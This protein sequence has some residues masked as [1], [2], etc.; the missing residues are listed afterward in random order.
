MASRGRTA[1]TDNDGGRSYDSSPDPLAMSM[2]ENTTQAIRHKAAG[3][4]PLMTNS[5]SKQNRTLEISGMDLDSPAKSMVLNTPRAGGASPWRIKVTVQAEPGSDEENTMSPS[6]KRVTRTKTTTVPLKDPDAQSPVK[7][8]RGRPRKSDTGIAAKPRRNGTPVK[9]T[10]RSKSRDASVGAA[11]SSA[12][13]VDTD[14]PPKKRRGRPRKSIQPPTEDEET[15]NIQDLVSDDE[16]FANLTPVPPANSKATGSKKTTRFATPKVASSEE[17]ADITQHAE[18]PSD[19]TPEINLGERLHGRKGTPH[20]KKTSLLSETA[21]DGSDEGSEMLTPS[22][23]EDEPELQVYDPDKQAADEQANPTPRQIFEEEEETHNIDNYAFDEG[24]TRMPDD[25]TVLDSENF[26]MISVDSL[27]SNG[28]FSSPPKPEDS[29]GPTNRSIGT[30]LDTISGLSSVVPPRTVVQL[31]SSHSSVTSNPTERLRSTASPRYSTPVVE[32]IEQPSEPPAIQVAPPAIPKAVTP[33]I[34]RVV[35][36]GVALQGLVDTNRTTP[37]PLQKTHDEKRDQLDDLF[38]GFSEGTRKELHAGLRLGEQLADGQI[39]LPSPEP[40]S[41][42]KPTRSV[43][44]REGVFRTQRKS[45]SRLL[46]PEEQEDHV[47]VTE[48]RPVLQDDVQYPLLDTEEAANSLISPASSEDGMNSRGNTPPASTTSAA[49]NSNRK[50]EAEGMNP[51]LVASQT[52]QDDYADI[53]Q[54]EASRSSNSLED[55][56]QPSQGPSPGTDLFTDIATTVPARGK[57]IRTRRHRAAAAPQQSVDAKSTQQLTPPSAESGNDEAGFASARGSNQALEDKDTSDTNED[58]DDTGMFFQSNM[59]TVF[60]T[61]TNQRRQRTSEKASLS[62]LLDQGE[63]LLPESSPPAQAKEASPTTTKANPFLGTPPRFP[64]FPCSPSKSSPLRREIRGSDIS[65][66][67]IQ[68]YQDESSLPVIQSSPFRSIVEGDSVLSTASDQRQFR[69]E[70]EGATASSILR[71]RE[72][73]NE[74][75][76]AY[77]PQERSLNEITEVTEPSRTWYGESTAPV[78]SSSHRKPQ[79]AQSTKSPAYKSSPRFSNHKAKDSS[80]TPEV[81]RLQV[82]ME[83][84]ALSESSV[85]EDTEATSSIGSVSEVIDKTAKCP[86]PRQPA[87]SSRA[88]FDLFEVLRRPAPPAAHPILARYAAL[89]KIEPW[90]KTHYKTLDKLYATHLKHPALFLP[91]LN[92]P[93]ALSNTNDHLAQ[94]FLTANKSPYIGATFSAWGYS[95]VM[96]ESLV[97]LCAVFMELLTL[98]DIKQ[99]ESQNKSGIELGNCAPGRT[100]DRIKGDEVIKRLATIVLGED[101]RSDEKKGLR[102]DRSKTMTIQWPQ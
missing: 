73:A 7:R 3:R 92:P 52:Q 69:V 90:T 11:G 35:T 70:M 99:Y 12:A 88:D 16:M 33:H 6:V 31:G 39:D 56:A 68:Q 76:D 8:P 24:T 50:Q 67:S 38:R 97:V 101:V 23:E 40:S 26:S 91:S 93:T 9:K 49:T 74:Y 41:P 96:S 15:L 36:A 10:A 66:D 47:L 14:V 98:E 86:K 45:R 34:D 20:A 30:L 79:L 18:A 89:P 5:S 95:M 25:T 94:R 37:D 32:D 87:A 62:S 71:V 4:T 28:G 57:Q 72:E 44:P 81:A 102:I 83:E 13:D 54:E 29:Q 85:H 77:E 84:E 43:P 42:I 82:E 2:D 58:S 46:T 51:R 17:T 65:S 61:R 78:P 53:W 75:L 27:P 21:H 80:L 48:E 55:E 19:T 59:P 63:S 60:N 64:G 100:G 1:T 22:S